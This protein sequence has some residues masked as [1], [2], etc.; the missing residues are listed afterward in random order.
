MSKIK[1]PRTGKA[2]YEQ[3]QQA[4][5][6]GLNAAQCPYEYTSR[7]KDWRAGWWARF[8]EVNGTDLGPPETWGTRKSPEPGQETGNAPGAVSESPGTG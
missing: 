6:A 2:A 5:D 7:G 1:A 8:W 4:H 3:G